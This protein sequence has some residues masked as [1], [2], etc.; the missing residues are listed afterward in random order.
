MGNSRNNIFIIV[1]IVIILVFIPSCSGDE[2]ED[3]VSDEEEVISRE[4][5]E[6]DDEDEGDLLEEDYDD[7]SLVS[8][9]FTGRNIPDELYSRSRTVMA[10]IDN[11]GPA[12][13]QDGLMEAPIV[14]EVLAE[15]GISRLLPVYWQ[16]IPE[17]IGPIRSARSYIIEIAQEYNAL[18]LHAG[19]SPGG[20]EM[21]AENKVDNLDQLRQGG[22]YWRSSER[23]MPHNLYTGQEKIE[24]YIHSLTGQEYSP[25]FKYKNVTLLEDD[26]TR[27]DKIT[28]RYWQNYTV[29]YKFDRD[30]NRYER[31]IN[32]FTSPHVT[33][34]GEHITVN[35]IIV[36]YVPMEIKDSEGRLDIDLSDEGEALVFID[37]TVKQARWENSEDDYTRY[38]EM[39]TNERIKLNPGRTWIQIAF[40]STPVDFTGFTED[41]YIDQRD[42]DIR[43]LLNGERDIDEIF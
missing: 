3:D 13:P 19:A 10:V 35:N 40:E 22:Y 25:R 2:T 7:I 6:E 42:E 30:N 9:P 21:L 15:G 4:D 1:V 17:N 20:F 14:Y 26:E 28:I 33:N 38:Y 16:E 31:Y 12:R 32:G 29:N 37:G 39:G 34:E 5:F 23:R 24:D 18:L 8:H 36:R 43:D 41:E 11:I 27:A